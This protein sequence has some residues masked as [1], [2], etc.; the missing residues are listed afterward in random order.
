MMSN[1]N[2]LFGIIL[3]LGV[4]ILACANNTSDVVN[5]PVPNNVSNQD[6]PN[7]PLPI[8]KPPTD[9]PAKPTD[10]PTDE[11][12]VDESPVSP[13]GDGIYLVGEEIAEGNWKSTGSGFGCK[14]TRLD[15]NKEVLRK[16]VG[17]AGGTLTIQPG[18]YEV[19]MENCG[20]WEFVEGMVFEPQ[21]DITA[22]KMDGFYIV[23]IEISSGKWLSDRPGDGCYWAKLD[24][25]QVIIEQYFGHAGLIT[26]EPEV[27]EIMMD[28][29]G[30]W[31]F[32][33]PQDDVT[34]P[35]VDGY[36]IVGIEIAAG[37][38]ES[39]GTGA[40]CYWARIAVT[41][42][43]IENHDGLAGGTMIIQPGDYMVEMEGCGTWEFAGP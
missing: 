16:F 40:E 37:K 31:E 9:I 8:Y 21:D 24:K 34:A 12:V 4:A 17:N 5:N 10:V 42:S 33:I 15:E 35:K 28:Q 13:K 18:D 25:N 39:N 2:K 32:T 7:E 26:I 30:T 11:P 41:Q 14:W 6:Q 19:E 38:W 1:R 22:P 29:C 43:V 27:Y 36:Y 3:V 23:G 20:T